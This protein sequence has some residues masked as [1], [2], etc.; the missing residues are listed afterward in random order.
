MRGNLA[1]RSHVWLTGSGRLRCQQRGSRGRLG[2]FVTF[3]GKFGMRGKWPRPVALLLVTG[4]FVA[5]CNGI[6]SPWPGD[7]GPRS[8]AQQSVS[9]L[10]LQLTP[11]HKAVDVAPGK[12]VVVRATAGVLEKV[13]L[14]GA[15]GRVVKGRLGS[16]GTLW[17]SSEPLG[18]GKKYT[19]KAQGLGEDGKKLSRTSTFRTVEPQHQL[20]VQMTVPDGAKVGVGMP[21]GFVFSGPVADKKAAERMLKV[22]SEPTTRGGF[23]WF[24]DSWVVW[25][26]RWYWKPG[27]KIDIDADIYGRN[28][29]GGAYGAEDRSASMTIGDKV[30]AVANGK[31]HR[32]TVEI[33]N[34]KVRTMPIAMGRPT[35]PTPS[36]WYTVMSEHRPYTMDSSTYGVAVDSEQGY[37]IKVTHATRMSYSGIFYHS[38]PW[39]VWAQGSQNVSHGCINLSTE[40][41]DWLMRQSRPGDLIRVVG[42]G[43][44]R[45]EPSDG[46]SVWQLTWSEW[47]TGGKRQ[48]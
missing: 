47:Q 29:G 27:T 24:S 41:A 36:G 42:S 13:S 2:A 43:G 3:W 28:L 30:V 18:Y 17:T 9:P 34:R 1:R 11:K 5:G 20:S 32:M 7:G 8:G 23:Y 22:T 25:R 38:A 33:N 12:A 16:E 6:G 39:S 40:N 15:N 35:H 10:S 37:R 31:T 26:P 14:T 21:I 46:W 4:L 44:P 48:S 45:L 19:L